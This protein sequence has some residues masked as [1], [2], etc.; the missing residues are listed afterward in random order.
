MVNGPFVE[1]VNLGTGK[2]YSVLEMIDTFERVNGIKVP[3]KIMERR[4]GD[5]AA[6]YADPAKAKHFLNWSASLNL[7]DIDYD[8]HI[9]IDLGATSLQ[10]FSILSALANEFSVSAQDGENYAYTVRDISAYIERYI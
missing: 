5:V 8:A 1:A 6:C 3:Y 7:E 10:Y 2:G 4:S 9:M